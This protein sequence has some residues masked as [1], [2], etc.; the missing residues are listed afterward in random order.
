ME[1]FMVLST[2]KEGTDMEDVYAVVPE[3]QARVAVLVAEGRLGSV[4]LSPTRGT[5]FIEAFAETL[6][7]AE[8]TAHSLPMAKWWNIDVY[9]LAPPARPGAAS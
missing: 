3:E 7:E 1:K 8:A 9:P 6:A 5:V 4:Y 2:F